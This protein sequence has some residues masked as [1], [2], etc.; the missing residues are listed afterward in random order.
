MIDLLYFSPFLSTVSEG[1]VVDR[2]WGSMESQTA[3]VET[4][5]VFGLFVGRERRRVEETLVDRPENTVSLQF[6]DDQ[7]APGPSSSTSPRRR[8]R[9]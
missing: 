6:L 7:V 2:D 1:N 8:G 4:E 3:T 5:D 9:G